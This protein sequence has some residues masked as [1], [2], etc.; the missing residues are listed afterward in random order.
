[1]AVAAGNEKMADSWNGL[2]G[3]R[4]VKHQEMMDGFLSPLGASGLRALAAKPGEKIID[5]GCGS[6]ATSLELALAVGPDGAVL[7]VDISE[8]L[9]GLARQRA[10]AAGLSVE[11]AHADAQSHAFH[12]PYDAIFSRFGVMFFAD[13]VAAFTNMHRALRPGGRLAFVCWQPMDKNP[14]FRRPVDAVLARL[15]SAVDRAAVAQTMM[16]TPNEPGPFAFEDSARVTDIL[17]RAGFDDIQ[18]APA[19][20]SHGALTQEAFRDALV[21]IGPV[22]RYLETNPA[23]KEPILAALEESL[24]KPFTDADGNVAVPSA[25]WIVTASKRQ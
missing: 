22:S 12:G 9:L 23:L 24:I 18:V 15:D 7:G 2:L 5:V 8:T 1:M 20:D 25:T 6:G 13:P 3:A 21:S 14:F 4:W 19:A 11:F 16:T 10:A 17:R